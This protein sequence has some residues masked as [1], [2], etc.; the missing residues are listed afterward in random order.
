MR[1]SREMIFSFILI[2][3]IIALLVVNF[4]LPYFSKETPVETSQTQSGDKLRL[5]QVEWRKRLTAN[6]YRIMREKGTE[7]PF[8]GKYNDFFERGIYLCSAC[9]LPLFSSEDKIQSKSG[10]PSF[11][12][13][14]NDKS[15]I[16]KND[17]ML[18]QQKKE[19]LC[20]RCDSH[21]GELFN[22][23]PAPSYKRYSIN[24]IALTFSP[25]GNN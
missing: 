17:S 15:V 22:D 25:S 3:A 4:G 10:Y 11:T 23:G 13:P 5:S 1:I 19:V 18:T 14:M 8:S 9:N 21:L 6:Q 16:V 24:S 20:S 12:K 2:G 7:A